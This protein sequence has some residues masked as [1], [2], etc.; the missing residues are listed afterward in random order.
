LKTNNGDL[1][2]RFPANASCRVTARTSSGRI[3]SDI[4]TIKAPADATEIQGALGQG[5]KPHIEI[6]ADR[7]VHLTTGAKSAAAGS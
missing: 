1:V 3:T 2:V 4:P 6:D 7:N 5:Q